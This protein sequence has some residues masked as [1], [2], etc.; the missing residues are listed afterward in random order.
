MT[1]VI[2]KDN[3]VDVEKDSKLVVNEKAAYAWDL[4]ET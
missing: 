1:L 2:N 3:V 4:L